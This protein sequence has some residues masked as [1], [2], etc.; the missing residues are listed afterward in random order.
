MGSFYTN[1]TVKT[2]DTDGIAVAIRQAGRTAFIAPPENGATVV[3][4]EASEDQDL[5]ILKTLALHLARTCKCPTLGILNHDDDVLVYVLYDGGKLV[6]EYNSA[7]GYFDSDADAAVP[8]AGGNAK[9]LSAALGAPDR[10]ADIERILR[11]PGNTEDG[12]VFATDRHRE[13]VS[14]LGL[15]GAAVGAGFT[16]LEEGELPEGL[17]FDALVRVDGGS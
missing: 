8:P 16:Y 12:F 3:F 5:E 15:P 9:R 17:E 1:I 7:P 13:L 11:A 14:V 2:A 4:D 6:D 10:A